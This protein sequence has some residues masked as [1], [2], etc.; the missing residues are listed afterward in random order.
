MISH[1]EMHYKEAAEKCIKDGFSAFVD[2][3]NVKAAIKAVQKIHQ[4]AEYKSKE[5]KE[6][7]GFDDELFKQHPN[8]ET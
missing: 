2:A 5:E 7:T 3:F 8:Y 4:A 6:K 1:P